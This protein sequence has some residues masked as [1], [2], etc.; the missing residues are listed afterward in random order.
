[1]QSVHHVQTTSEMTEKH[2]ITI[3]DLI[4]LLL[5][6]MTIS[7]KQSFVFNCVSYKR[8]MKR[9]KWLHL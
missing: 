3:A 7:G 1:M 4:K 6:F 8:Y 9:N 5:F 2:S